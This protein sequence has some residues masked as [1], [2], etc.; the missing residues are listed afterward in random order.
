MN[1]SFDCLTLLLSTVNKIVNTDIVNPIKI[2][3]NVI[4]LF[5]KLE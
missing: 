2:P 5:C 1:V 3:I 4:I